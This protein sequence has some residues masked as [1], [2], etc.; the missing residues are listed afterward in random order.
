VTGDLDGVVRVGPITGA[1]PHL[2]FGHELQISSVAVSPDSRW[3]ASASQD[4]TIRLW[5][6]PDGTPFHAL[7]YAEILERLQGL[8]NL[9]V[10]PDDKSDTGYRVE[11]GP[12][13][14][15]KKLPEW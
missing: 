12:F 4:G 13:P 15:W 11:V 14:G 9:R 7:P 10:V 6:M 2:L 5:P 3:I 8:T 1:E